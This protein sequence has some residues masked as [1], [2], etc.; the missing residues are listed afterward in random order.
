[1]AQNVR[2]ILLVD[3]GDGHHAFDHAAVLGAVNALR[4]ASTARSARPSGI[5]SACAQ[6]QIC[7]Y[8]MAIFLSRRVT[9]LSETT[10]RRCSASCLAEVIPGTA[11]SSTRSEVTWFSDRTSNA[12]C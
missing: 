12:Y 10:A 4:C 6:R 9:L 5:D 1:M 11:A 7:N 3:L 2:R 8:V